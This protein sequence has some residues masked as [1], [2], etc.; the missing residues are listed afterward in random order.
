MFVYCDI[1]KP[2]ILPLS[3]A[4]GKQWARGRQEQSFV[5]QPLASATL[6]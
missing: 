5:F 1:V 4:W 2:R 3:A 6:D